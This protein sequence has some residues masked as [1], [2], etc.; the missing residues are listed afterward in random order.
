MADKSSQ[1]K[2]RDKSPVAEMIT[3]SEVIKKEKSKQKIYEHFTINPR[4][5]FLYSDKPCENALVEQKM[6]HSQTKNPFL[7]ISKTSALLDSLKSPELSQDILSKLT[8]INQTPGQKYKF[9]QTAN[10]DIGW[11]NQHSRSLSPQRSS[12]QF[13]YPKKTCNETNYANE[14]YNMLRVSPFSNKFK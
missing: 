2:T 11:F 5:L 6:Q 13:N 10:Q 1:V 3:W 7:D 9:P 8:T 12:N 14:Y 4:K